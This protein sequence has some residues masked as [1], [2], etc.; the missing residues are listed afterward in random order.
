[1]PHVKDYGGPANS[2][3]NQMSE[4]PSQIGCEKED[5]S[6]EVEQHLETAVFHR[7]KGLV[8]DI[9]SMRKFSY[10]C[11]KAYEVFMNDSEASP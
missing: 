7:N 8:M 5:E 4:M 6:F 1:M 3:Y 2:S 10:K 9:Q 11:Q